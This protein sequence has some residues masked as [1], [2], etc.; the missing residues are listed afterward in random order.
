[1]AATDLER[2]LHRGL[3]MIEIKSEDDTLTVFAIGG[4]VSLTITEYYPALQQSHSVSIDL[5]EIQA[6]KLL[7]ALQMWSDEY[8]K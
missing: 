4:L 8:G 6:E 5:R 1:M 3:S 7:K 2:L